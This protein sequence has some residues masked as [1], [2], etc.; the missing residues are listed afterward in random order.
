[1]KIKGQSK[2]PWFGI[3]N[4][5]FSKNF[6]NGYYVSRCKIPNQLLMG[7]HSQQVE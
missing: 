1:M 7:K 5:N 4:G 2:L 6:I 3:V